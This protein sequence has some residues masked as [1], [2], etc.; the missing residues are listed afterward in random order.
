[1]M[2]EKSNILFTSPSPKQSL[3]FSYDDTI[4][5][6]Y[7]M[8]DDLRNPTRIRLSMLF[9]AFVAVFKLDVLP[10]RRFAGAVQGQATLLGLVGQILF[11]DD[12]IVHHHIGKTDIHDDDALFYANHV[13]GHAH[14]TFL[15]R[16]QRIPE[17]S[18]DRQIVLRRRFRFLTEEE[19][20]PDDRSNHGYTQPFCERHRRGYETVRNRGSILSA[21]L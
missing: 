9:P 21:I 13:G 3:S 17:I 1:M 10:A 5:V 8:L 12:R 14:T 6:I 4:Q 2:L 7:L 15:I 20:I 19:Y 18:A 11:Y 16:L